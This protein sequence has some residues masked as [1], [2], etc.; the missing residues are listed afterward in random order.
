MSMERN[1]HMTDVPASMPCAHRNTE[2]RMGAWERRWDTRFTQDA[3]HTDTKPT[4]QPSAATSV[5][6]PSSPIQRHH[7]QCNKTGIHTSLHSA[8]CTHSAHYT[9]HVRERHSAHCAK[10]TAGSASKTVVH[11]D[12]GALELISMTSATWSG[13]GGCRQS[14][15]TFVSLPQPLKAEGVQKDRGMGGL[16]IRTF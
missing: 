13:R 8:L 11:G 9:I 4:L 14:L 16:S 10:C 6:A 1:S 7:R 15:L 5:H 2:H 3:P 12:A